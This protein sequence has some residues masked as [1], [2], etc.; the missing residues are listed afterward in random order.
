MNT[1]W[2]S[3]LEVW[4]A[5]FLVALGHKAQ[6]A[7]CPAYIAGLIGPGDRK[8]VQPM[9]AR[10]GDIPYDRLHHFVSASVWDSAPLE[11][12]LW[13]HADH[14]VGGERS[15]LIID[16][17]SLPKKGEHSV[18]VA[19]QYASTLG[20]KAN[21]QT[22]V[23]V[24]LTS[25][26]VPLMLSLRLFL[27]DI[28]TADPARLKRASVPLEHQGSR[29]KPEMAIEEID[30][31]CA[32]GVR[33]G[34]VLA[35]TGYGLSAPFRQALNARGLRWAVGIPRH[36]KVCSTDVELVFPARKRGP[37]RMH[38]VPDQQSVP[39]HK[40]LETATWRRVSWRRGT[41]GGLAARFAAMRIR[42]ADGPAQRI[43]GQTAQHMPGEEAW[44]TGEHR[45]TGERKYYLSNLSADTSLRLLA[46]AIKARWVY[47]QAHQQLR[48]ELGLDYF[49]GRSWT[50]LH[51][52]ALMSMMAYAF[53]QSRRLTAVGRKKKSHRPTTTAQSASN[54]TGHS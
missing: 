52:H 34:C 5:P 37:S 39:A 18:G 42:V 44:L 24:T 45:S 41:K 4:L 43:G 28:W 50:G 25:R 27:P 53:L 1:D 2:R 3:D 30:R 13:R 48:E 54:T 12:A 38:P 10:N 17:T 19:P 20:K 51:R 22:L 40:I 7:M 16:D 15:W 26:E 6:R 9:A 47:E 31:L 11:A 29:T 21:C 35:D 46:A 8:S 33:F 23:S 36:Q 32:T 49:E 14:L